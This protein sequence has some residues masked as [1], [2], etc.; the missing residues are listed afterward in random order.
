[1]LDL[2][3]PPRARRRASL[4]PMIDVVFLL[5]IFFMLAA[6]FGA[7]NLVPLRTGGDGGSTYSGPPRLVELRGDGLHL[8]GQEVDL[9]ALSDR[10]S[11]LMQSPEDVIILRARDG[12]DVQALMRVI[13]TLGAAGLPNVALVE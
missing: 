11:P 2:S 5:L 6:R 7:E 1:M 4:T 13:D 12:A 3:P 10:L 8:N 9:S